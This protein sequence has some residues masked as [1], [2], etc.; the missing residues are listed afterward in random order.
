[1][2]GQAAAQAVTEL[3]SRVTAPLRASRRPFRPAPV[4]M[5]MLVSASTLPVNELPVPNVAE[6]P[7]CQKTF[8]GQ[9]VAPLLIS[10]TE[11]ALAVVS[12]DPIWKRKNAFG[13]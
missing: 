2:I 11:D 6:L 10:R 9:V 4:V 3:V 1:M 5:V 8:G 7:T 13:F 12:V